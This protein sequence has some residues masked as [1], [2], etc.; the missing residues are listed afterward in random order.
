MLHGD[1]T[2]L[3]YN[4]RQ[5]LSAVERASARIRSSRRLT[6]DDIQLIADSPHWNPRK[7]WRWPPAEERRH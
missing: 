4:K 1:L 7:F 5:D 2:E 6:Y 3:L